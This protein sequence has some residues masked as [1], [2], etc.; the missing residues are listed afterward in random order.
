MNVAILNA[1]GHLPALQALSAALGLPPASTWKKGQ[2]RRGGKV[3]AAD[4]LQIEIADE[5]SPAEL[6]RSIQRFIA[7]CRERGVSFNTVASAEL[8]I[9][10]T[11]GD[12]EQ[13]V[14]GLEF[15]A[16]ELR[17][18]S[19][20]GISLSIMAYPTRDHRHFECK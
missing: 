16:S 1:E 2:P 14:A 10:F 4:G 18:I 13:F 3:H 7:K 12:S 17:A 15:S 20:C 8:S 5:K 19:E 11:V 9:G 6:T